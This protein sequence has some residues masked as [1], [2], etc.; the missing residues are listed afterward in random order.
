MKVAV[1]LSPMPALLNPSPLLEEER[2]PRRAALVTKRDYPFALHWPGAWTTFPADNHPIDP[3][4]VDA[5]EVLQQGFDREKAHGSGSV[6]EQR[7]PRQTVL[8]VLD[9]D[10]PPDVRQLREGSEDLG[11]H[12]V[13]TVRSLCEHLGA[14]ANGPAP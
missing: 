7:N 3:S 5:S 1:Q 14:C 11:Q 6:S 2:H 4:K 9:A 12:S 10:S 8:P 13:Q